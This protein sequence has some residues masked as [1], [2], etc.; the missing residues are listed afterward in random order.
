MTEPKLKTFHSGDSRFYVDPTTKRKAPGVTSVLGM[1]A[2]PWLKA[3]AAKMVAETAV[4]RIGEWTAV[5]GAEGHDAAV[6]WLKT[7][8]LKFTQD[9]ADVGTSAHDV[10]ERMARGETVEELAAF[11]LFEGNPDLRLYA[12]HFAEFQAAFQPE[13][14]FLEETIWNETDDYAG[15]FDWIAVI[16]GE[17]VIGDNKTTRS[18]VHEEV[19]LQLAAYR[20]GEKIIHSDGTTTPLPAIVAG[21]VF[22][23]R[24][25]GWNLYPVRCDLP[26]FERF[27]AL[28]KMFTWERDE[29]RGVIGKPVAK[30][31]VSA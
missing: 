1:L 18:G 19:A 5:L 25:E 24:P 16:D 3:W 17:V 28:R 31:E 26:V 23:V 30:P 2:K 6:K 10:F 12:S 4:D 15:S 29:K 21:A 20:F 7:T 13:F 22:H 11:G 9:A 27:L 8:P 14:L